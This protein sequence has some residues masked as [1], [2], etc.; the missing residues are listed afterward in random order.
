MKHIKY[1]LFIILNSVIVYTSY[2]QTVPR[3]SIQGT[4]MDA[5]GRAVADGVH[6]VEFKLY[7]MK[8]GGTPIWNENT[9]VE[10]KDGIY[11]HYLGSANPLEEEFFER[12]LFVAL[13]IGPYELPRTEL[14]YVPYTFT[15]NEARIAGKVICSG[16]V[17]DV[18]HSVL[19]PA[20]FA[21]ENGACWVPMRGQNI[22]GSK[23]ANI[24]SINILPDA[25]GVFI[26]AHEY[27]DG[28]DLDRT[29]SSPIATLQNES[30]ISHGHAHSLATSQNG[31]HSHTIPSNN[32]GSG[33]SLNAR[34]DE[35]PPGTSVPSASVGSHSHTITGSI[36]ASGGGDTR[37][38]NLNVYIYVRID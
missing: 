18:K 26:R 1:F 31:A 8:E 38:K 17:G 29:P 27:N 16:A 5:R 12:T 7:E 28:V 34:H 10:S 35:G 9:T 19:T 4:L 37:P 3:I 14:S 22:F 11:S 25:G 32:G 33:S 24:L 36:S 20:Q 13:Q 23:L 2:A 6:V 15:A 21:L 30:Y